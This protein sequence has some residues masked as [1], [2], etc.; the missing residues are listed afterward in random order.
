MMPAHDG[1]CSR[2]AAVFRRLGLLLLLLLLSVAPVV[3]GAEGGDD[4]AAAGPPGLK[5]HQAA[6]APRMHPRFDALKAAARARRESLA[7]QPAAAA[8]P[9]N[10]AAERLSKLRRRP[11]PVEYEAAEAP[12]VQDLRERPPAADEQ[13]WAKEQAAVAAEDNIERAPAPKVAQQ[14]DYAA[15]KVRCPCT[16]C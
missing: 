2:K 16:W 11:P 3:R 1:A 15:T 13:V 4:E 14:Y 5:Q 10:A 8:A 6:D 12:K 7:G 9:G